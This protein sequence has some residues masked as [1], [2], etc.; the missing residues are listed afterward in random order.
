M[1]FKI[2]RTVSLFLFCTSLTRKRF[3]RFPSK[4]NHIINAD[5]AKNPEIVINNQLTFKSH[6]NNIWSKLSRSEV[7][8]ATCNPIWQH[9]F[10]V[11]DMLQIT[12]VHFSTSFEFY[13]LFVT[14]DVL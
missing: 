3:P 12:A 4:T 11:L 6:S 14:I 1:G 2:L 5:K 7:Q 10:C 13:V 9:C 8:S